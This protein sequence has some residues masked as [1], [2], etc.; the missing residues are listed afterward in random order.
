[1]SNWMISED[2][3]S[4]EQRH[5][6]D[7]EIRKSK[8]QWIKGFAGSGKSI[9]IVHGIYNLVKENETKGSKIKICVVVFT[10]SLKQLFI[11]GFRELNI[12]NVCI[13]TYHQFKGDSNSYDYIFCDE[14]QD[15][16]KSILEKMKANAKHVIAGGDSNQSIYTNDPDTNEPIVTTSEIGSILN[17]NAWELNTIYRL[18][19]SLIKAVSSL[20]PSMGILSSKTDNTKR[21]VTPNLAKA[22]SKEKEV[23]YVYSKAKDQL[24]NGEN[25]V[26]ILPS[27]RDIVEFLNK[28]LLLFGKNKWDEDNKDN[29]NRYGK[30]DYSKLNQY[31]LNNS[32]DL[33]YIGNGYGNLYEAGRTGKIIIMTYH[34]SKGLD[35]DNVYLPFMDNDKSTFFTET[36]FMVG[37]TRSKFALHITYSGNMHGFVKRIED[38]CNKIDI[39]NIL[40]QIGKSDSI[41]DFDF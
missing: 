6:I 24:S 5:F 40:N 1:M 38:C 19:Q 18:T 20:I 41:D 13:C 4:D 36:L 37:L 27:H 8:N 21:D 2:R 3:L 39:D 32:I 10:N 16:P 23:E 30:L 28:T 17:A 11:A 7:N 22:S 14:V 26:I 12:K 35:F 15:L 31:L 9:L 34:S 29:K 33:V 25:A